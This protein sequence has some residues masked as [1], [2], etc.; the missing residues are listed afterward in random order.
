MTEQKKAYHRAYYLA[1]RAKKKASVRAYYYAHKAECAARH[2][3]WEA[4]QP[5]EQWRARLRDYKRA[6][7]VAYPEATR[8]Q[9][10]ARYAES[11]G[12]LTKGPCVVCGSTRLVDGHHEDYAKPLEITWLCRSCHA[13]LHR[14]RRAEAAGLRAC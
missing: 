8:A 9:R 2:R 11:T 3:R 6:R 14:S 12:K 5:R 1:N 13:R 7:R 10:Q 4:A